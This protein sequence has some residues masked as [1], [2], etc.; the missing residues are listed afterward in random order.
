MPKLLKI[1]PSDVKGK[2]Y[3]AFFLLDNGKEKKV[4][5]GSSTYRDFT[6]MNNKKSKFYEAD[7][8]KREKVRA[9]YRARHAKDPINNPLTAGAL[10]WW[11]LWNKPT[12]AGS[13]S[14]FKNKFKL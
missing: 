10:S 12:L 3:S 6:L 9:S 2:K 5:F 7:K 4:N 14:H 8:E 11:I 13:I 1:I